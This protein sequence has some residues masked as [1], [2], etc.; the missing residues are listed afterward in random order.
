MIWKKLL[1]LVVI[2][3]AWWIAC[4]IAL[5]MFNFRDC[6]DEQ[7]RAHLVRGWWAILLI[8]VVSY[9]AMA[10]LVVRSKRLD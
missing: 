4:V 2:A 3:I 1:L 8:G 7:C 5:V 10:V 9:F 6:F